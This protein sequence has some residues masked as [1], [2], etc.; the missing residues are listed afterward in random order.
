VLFIIELQSISAAKFSLAV[1]ILL[2]N[3]DINN[4]NN[5]NNRQHTYEEMRP[6]S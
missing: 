4:N 3:N 2:Y 1:T 6:R 5:N